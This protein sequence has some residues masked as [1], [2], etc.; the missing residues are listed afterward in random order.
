MKTK[1]FFS[2]LCAWLILVQSTVFAY[3]PEQESAYRWAYNN[4]LTHQRTIEAA[5]MNW[6][7][8]K[9]SAA[10]MLINYMENVSGDFAFSW[11][12]C[13]F[14]DENTIS[15]E[16]RTY[17]KKVCAYGIMW[18]NGENFNPMNPVTKAQLWTIISRLMRWH[19]YD[20]PQGNYYT[21]HLEALKNNG[22]MSDIS[23]PTT[24][25]ARRWDFM[26]LLQKVNEKS[27]SNYQVYQPSIPTYTP[28][29]VAP[30][31]Q[32]KKTTTKEVAAS[33]MEYI[34][35]NNVNT[36]NSVISW[37]TV[38][39]SFKQAIDSLQEDKTLEE[40]IL[41]SDKI[42]SSFEFSTNI[43][44]EDLWKIDFSF[45]TDWEV[46]LDEL[47]GDISTK[48]ETLIDVDDAKAEI[49]WDVELRCLNNKLYARIKKLGVESDSFDPSNYESLDLV[50]ALKWKRIYV[51]LK[52]Y[53]D[54]LSDEDIQSIKDAFKEAKEK[55][56][57]LSDLL[58]NNGKTTY[59]G[60]FSDYKW[61]QW[62]KFSI[63]LKTIL[64]YINFEEILLSKEDMDSD[65]VSSIKMIIDMLN[66]LEWYIVI[67]WD[68]VVFIIENLDLYTSSYTYDDSYNYSKVYD[69]VWSM[70]ISYNTNWMINGYITD[71]NKMPVVAIVSKMNWDVVTTTVKDDDHNEVLTIKN[72]KAKSTYTFKNDELWSVKVK[73]IDKSTNKK[74]DRSYDISIEVSK[75]LLWWE[76]S[77]VIPFKTR[78]VM[79]AAS[80]IDVQTPSWAITIEEAEELLSKTPNM[81]SAQW[82]ARDVARKNDMAQIQTAIITSQQDRWAFP[83]MESNVWRDSNKKETTN[84]TKWLMVSEISDNLIKAWMR[85][86]PMDPNLSNKTYWLWQLKSLTFVKWWEYLYL[87]TK[88]NWVT[89]WWFAL[90]ATQETEGWSNRVV[91]ENKS[92]L[93]NWY[94][95]EWTDLKDIE[96]CS[97]LTKW[98][99][100]SAKNCT[101]KDESELRYI[102]LY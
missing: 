49:E 23:N 31:V 14:P 84:A 6:V 20:N 91:C 62:W 64:K 94:I 19:T 97:A 1:N 13:S 29:V 45:D 86:I 40:K 51:D 11:K 46:D 16:F 54:S 32:T 85:S 76:E 63:N 58:Y 71:E 25:Y 7:V 77:L 59:N 4:W 26:A 21:K 81:M 78:V 102:L 47:K 8:T 52:D 98:N 53:E 30:K 66:S 2:G 37:D 60:K 80:K 89:N 41:S 75:D 68:D 42:K 82:R 65:S 34:A 96:L 73:K 39:Y 35:K 50:E 100:C 61:R 93:E 87:V 83:G 57:K 24:T 12:L 36:T 67:S 15:P 55:Q 10:Q 3:T 69:Y 28:A 72:D 9:Q 22:F 90:M 95:E 44:Y 27:V 43:D 17:A 5:N 33:I 101:Y 88:R 56:L 38:S 79:E 70:S 18:T 92:G 74:I 99:S 48:L